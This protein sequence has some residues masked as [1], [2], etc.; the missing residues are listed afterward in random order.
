MVNTCQK[1]VSFD[2]RL[3]IMSL[4]NVVYIVNP[5]AFDISNDGVSPTG[6]MMTMQG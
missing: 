4:S 6:E 2:V 5:I 1:S 3:H